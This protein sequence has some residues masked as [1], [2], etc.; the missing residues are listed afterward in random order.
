VSSSSAI[1]FDADIMARYAQGGPRYTSYPTAPQFKDEIRPEEYARA[2]TASEDALL[3]RPLSLYVHVPFCFSPCLY[4]GCNKIVT[5]DLARIDHYSQHLAQEIA[6]RGAYF[7]QE[8]VV[9]QLHFGG[10]TPTYLPKSTLQQLMRV[11]ARHFQLSEASERDYS[12]EIDPRSVDRATLQLLRE[13][14]FNRLSL[15]VQDFDPQ[16]QIA[17]N[18]VQPPE[19]VQGVYHA[20]RDLGFQSINFDLI[21]GLPLQSVETFDR[22][23]DRVIAMRPDR[24]AVYG[25]AHMP[26]L[27]KAQRRF[28][29]EELPDA[30]TR[31]A[32]LQ[33]AIQRLGAAGYLYIG[34]DHFA[35]PSDTLAQAKRQQTLHRSFQG[36]TTHANRDL[37]SFGVSA[38]GRVGGLYLQNYKRLADYEAAI[39]RGVLPTERG[40]NVDQDDRIRGDVIQRI[41]CHG[42]VDIEAVQARHGI[43]FGEYFSLEMQRLQPLLAD[44]LVEVTDA[45]IRLTPAGQLLMRSVAMAFDAYLNA[46]SESAAMSRVV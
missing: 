2:A 39:E 15:G 5:R 21:Y 23:L 30:V 34:L 8:R 25:Y 22:T 45:H 13:L 40:I 28:H 19:M 11:L 43:V 46:D 10:G 7:N 31:M 36:Y 14:G 29:S 3:R 12:I 41:M 33:L 42:L 44:G 4:C 16:V 35:L 6:W 26:Q 27:F 37:V 18:R 9:E 32:L 1:Q 17:I 20:A 38:I 24:L